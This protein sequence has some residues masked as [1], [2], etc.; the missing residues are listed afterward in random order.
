VLLLL[1]LLLLL[2]QQQEVLLDVLCIA[3]N[4]MPEVPGGSHMF[5]RQC[6]AC[7]SPA[8]LV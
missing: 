5:E 4:Y 1:L 8:V 7:W 6:R 3:A 2:Q